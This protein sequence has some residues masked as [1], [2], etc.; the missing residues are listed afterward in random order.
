MYL[1]SKMGLPNGNTSNPIIVE[2][3]VT[4]R[5]NQVPLEI[6]SIPEISEKRKTTDVAFLITF[7]LGVVILLSVMIYTLCYSDMQRFTHGYDDCG[8]VCGSMNSYVEEVECSGKDMSDKPSSEFHRCSDNSYYYNEDLN[9]LTTTLEDIQ[10]DS[11]GLT[12][13]CLV[14]LGLSILSLILFRYFVKP[15]VWTMLT[16][17]VLLLWAVT[18]FMWY[19]YSINAEWLISSIGF[20]IISFIFSI[21]ILVLGLNISIIIFFFEESIRIVFAMPF[22]LIE[23]ILTFISN[24]VVLTLFVCTFFL[25]STSGRLQK[26]EFNRYDYVA[27]SAMLFALGWSIIMMLWTLQFILAC[28]Q[29]VIAGAIATY[30][31][32]RDKLTV[33]TPI[34][35]SF[36]NLI[37]YHLGTVAFGSLTLTLLTILKLIIRGA[38]RNNG[39]L[40]LIYYCLRPIENLLKYFTSMGYIET[41]IHGQPLC[42]SAS[43]AINLIISNLLSAVALNSVGNFV[44]FMAKLVIVILTVG[45][46]LLLKLSTVAVVFGGIVA[47]LCVHC[48]FVVFEVAVDTIF[49]CYCEDQC[50]NNGSSRPYQTTLDLYSQIKKAQALTIASTK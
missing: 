30:Y 5:R 31:F 15:F 40:R 21:C 17:S 46:G 23:P 22:I 4:F 8:N 36:Y 37:R 41:A 20:T 16:V 29:M 47:L 13:L 1:V 48:F 42:R 19:L 33:V 25:M 50:I 7:A 12:I 26:L 49:L 3:I 24:F 44:F 38:S 14:G 9:F 35:S 11:V 28:Q 34:Y 45:L 18:G 10:T 32:A 39:W 2:N 6:Y 43:R 27:D